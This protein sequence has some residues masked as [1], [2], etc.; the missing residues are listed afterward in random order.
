[1]W[2]EREERERTGATDATTLDSRLQEP[3]TI[4][5]TIR[6]WLDAGTNM[7]LAL[8]YLRYVGM[9]C[10]QTLFRSLAYQAQICEMNTRGM[11]KCA[12]RQHP[13][14]CL[15]RACPEMESSRWLAIFPSDTSAIFA[16]MDRTFIHVGFIFSF[17][18]RPYCHPE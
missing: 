11:G 6:S 7:M 14:E 12:T 1:M 15:N 8:V 3:V 5:S 4:R 18:V 9:S 17:T 16:V 10:C 2:G 13:G